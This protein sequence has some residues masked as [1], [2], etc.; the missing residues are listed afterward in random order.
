MSGLRKQYEKIA[1]SN[2]SRP[3]SPLSSTPFI[4]S[5]RASP[6]LLLVASLRVMWA[7]R[8]V[9]LSS[10]TCSRCPFRSGW[11]YERNVWARPGRE[12]SAERCRPAPGLPRTRDCGP[13]AHKRGRSAKA[14]SHQP[15]NLPVRASVSQ[16][17]NG[18]LQGAS[19]DGGGP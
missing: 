1:G 16:P 14:P 11:G 7:R 4:S 15:P 8:A 9:K 13:R 17:V 5:G 19:S 3:D 12:G 18:G 6:G 10:L 2:S